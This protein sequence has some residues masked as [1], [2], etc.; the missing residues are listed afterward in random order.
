MPL[1]RVSF[2][3]GAAIGVLLASGLCINTHA[4]H[5]AAPTCGA[6]ARLDHFITT[7]QSVRPRL[8]TSILTKLAARIW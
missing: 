7:S 5:S 4:V 6:P 1:K 2:L 3:S 8:S